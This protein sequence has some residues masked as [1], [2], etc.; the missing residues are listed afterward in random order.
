MTVNNKFHFNAG[1]PYDGRLSMIMGMRSWRIVSSAFYPW[2]SSPFLFFFR[3][4]LSISLLSSS[5]TRSL[6][7]SEEILFTIVVT[8]YR[9]HVYKLLVIKNNLRRKSQFKIVN[10]FLWFCS[11]IPPIPHFSFGDV[12]H[13]I[14]VFIALFPAFYSSYYTLNDNAHINWPEE[15]KIMTQEKEN[16]R[17]TATPFNG[18]G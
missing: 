1:I 18:D 15:G 12:K 7:C 14:I 17:M 2:Y 13:E 3:C 11:C 8:A 16:S 5:R 10:H 4:Q 9:V 6:C